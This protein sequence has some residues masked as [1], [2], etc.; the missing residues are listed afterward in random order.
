MSA[1]RSA[2]SSLS[3]DIS[4]SNARWWDILAYCSK[5]ESTLLMYSRS[6]SLIG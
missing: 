3:V 6:S 5:A 4:P 1:T 2:S